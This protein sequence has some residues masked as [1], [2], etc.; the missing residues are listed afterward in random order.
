L[1]A[2]TTC[3]PDFF[4]MARCSLAFVWWAAVKQPPGIC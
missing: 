4:A 3:L 1:R 2:F